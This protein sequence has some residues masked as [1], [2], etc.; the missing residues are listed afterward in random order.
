MS[1]ARRVSAATVPAAGA[2][3]GAAAAKAPVLTDDA[4]SS[5]FLT[6]GACA[7]VKRFLLAVQTG[8]PAAPKFRKIIQFALDAITTEVRREMPHQHG[9]HK[10]HST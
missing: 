8:V 7:D 5:S 4:L 1:V 3:A 10:T 2:G 6:K 9:A